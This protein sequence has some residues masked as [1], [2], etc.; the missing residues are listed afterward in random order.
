MTHASTLASA[1]PTDRRPD[2]TATRARHASRRAASRSGRG[3]ALTLTLALGLTAVTLAGWVGA[4]SYYGTH[5]RGWDAQ[6]YYAHLRSAVIDG[7]LAIANEL[8]RTQSSA[9]FDG[10]DAGPWGGLPRR[11]DG[12]PANPYTIGS[13]VAAAPAFLAAHAWSLA[14]GS[15]ADGYARPYEAAVTLWYGLIAVLG[16]LALYAALAKRI[17]PP[18][19]AIG[20]GLGFLGTGVAYYAGVFPLMN[21]ATSFGAL[22]TLTAL[23]LHLHDRPTH[24]AAW[25][26]A[27]G[28]A[29]LIVLTRP[30]DAT[31]LLVLLPAWLRLRG[32]KAKAA[33]ATLGAASVGL[34]Y[35]GQ[36]LV[37]R[38]AFGEWVSNAYTR[39]TGGQGFD[40]TQPRILD[41][42]FSGQGGG[43]LFHPLLGVGLLGLVLAVVVG[44]R[45]SAG[46]RN[47]QPISDA[48]Q[49]N[50]RP[51]PGL[52][53]PMLLAMAAAVAAHA[54]AYSCWV[55]WDSGTSFGNRVF[56]NSTPMVMVGLAWWAAVAL[57]ARPVATRAASLGLAAG[58]ACACLLWNGLLLIN[59]VEQR[60]PA[61]ETATAA[62]VWDAQIDTLARLTGTAP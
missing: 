24:K 6:L 57:R 27:A 5:F 40:F 30:T 61:K 45:P 23:A 33:V 60:L 20:V 47:P 16:A 13:A 1:A 34:A 53:R 3:L 48:L 2:P 7:D 18:A 31:L 55:S 8:E 17:T 52:S 11:V 42:L 37:W 28:L 9:I 35:G 25:A 22:A 50:K 32:A 38:I 36:L 44:T 14:N 58:V 54:L 43:W 26:A 12:G 46:Q 4:L 39:W 41:L 56:V 15:L 21:H 62:A 10:P 51:A 49:T 29:F 19:A 59:D